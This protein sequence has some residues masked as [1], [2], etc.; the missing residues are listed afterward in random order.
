MCYAAPRRAFRNGERRLAFHNRGRSNSSVSTLWAFFIF[1]SKGLFHPATRARR[2]CAPLRR[3]RGLHA[4]RPDLQLDADLWAPAHCSGF[5]FTYASILGAHGFV[6]EN[7]V[8][9]GAFQPQPSFF[10]RVTATGPPSD[11]LDHT[12]RDN[13]TRQRARGG[14]TSP[15]ASLFWLQPVRLQVHW[16]APLAFPSGLNNAPKGLGR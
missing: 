5:S 6:T 14:P 2:S 1:V 8:G 15:P 7:L 10:T 13:L 3:L 12:D 9:T 4:P 11:H 16:E